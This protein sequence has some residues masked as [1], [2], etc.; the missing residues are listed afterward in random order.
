[1]VQ[2]ISRLPLEALRIGEASS[3]LDRIARTPYGTAIGFDLETTGRNPREHKL[4]M[5]QLKPRNKRPLIIDARD[6]DK[7][8]LRDT[9]LPFIRDSKRTFLGQNLLFELHWMLSYLGMEV[10]DLRARFEDT[11]LRELA[12][13]GMGFSDARKRGVAVNMHDIGE[14]YG[15]PI[16]K[17]ERSWFIDLDTRVEKRRIDADDREWEAEH[18]DDLEFYDEIPG[19]MYEEYRPWD[20]P[21]PQAQLE[22]A[23]QDVSVVHTIYDAQQKIIE[24]YKLQSVV[25]LEA[26]VLPATAGMQHYGMAVDREK[27]LGIIGGISQ[28]AEEL[29]AQLHKEIDVPVLEHRKQQ[30]LKKN[31]PYQEWVQAKGEALEVAKYIWDN[32]KTQLVQD[33]SDGT[34]TYKGWGDFKKSYMKK[35]QEENPKPVAPPALKDGVNLDSPAQ[36][37]IAFRSR[38]HQI[39]SAADEALAPLAEKDQVIQ[40]YLDYK[41]HSTAKS[42]YGEKYLDEHAPGGVIYPSVQQLGTETGRFSFKEP[43]V[44]QIPSKGVG[45]S[46]RTA[47]VPRPGYVFIDAD[48]KNVE[49]MITAWITRDTVML[50]AFEEGADLH[51][52]TAEVMFGLRNNSEYLAALEAGITPKDWTEEHDAVVGG[53]TLAGTSYRSIAK[54]I[55][56]GLLYGMGAGRLAATLRIPVE[57]AKELMRLYRETYRVAVGWLRKQ[58]DR[59]ERPNKDGRV[60]ASTLAGRRRWFDVPVL[61]LDKNTTAQEAQEAL[62][63]HK[64]R[65]AEI[66]RQ[67]GNHPIQGTSADITKLAIALWQERYNCP[68][69]RL[70]ATVHDELLIEV[71]DEPGLIERAN[72]HLGECMHEALTHFLVDMPAKVPVGAVAK[73]WK[74]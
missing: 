16:H 50:Q 9:L 39:N 35:W 68:D 41:A 32:T 73:Y 28:R 13:L 64:A 15:I 22:Y 51:A 69:A 2:Q 8:R 5:V 55:N 46:L 60:Y 70:V 43:N 4:V 27:W 18:A 25:D 38:G 33:Y 11:M 14:R 59:V 10:N 44:Q 57:A 19:A 42:K 20:E 52:R 21:F 63:K 6:E 29:A 58:G 26:R 1:M 36:I 49:L 65:I 30:W 37:L 45:A 40:L 31:E 62:D 3:E 12:I 7:G 47:I 48:F 72:R 34:E 56:F 53:K 74:H 54:T 24:E 71:R 61:K 23:R 67:L 17:E 66:R